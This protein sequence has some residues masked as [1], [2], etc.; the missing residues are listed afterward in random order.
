MRSEN[1]SVNILVFNCGSSS[2]KYKLIKMPQEQELAAGEAQRLGIK[3]Q[4]S[5]LIAHVA[6]STERSIAVHLPD[7]A[8]AFKKVIELLREDRRH[9]KSIF[10]DV[11]AHRYVHPEIFSRGR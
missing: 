2:L 1:S 3:T 9:D 7:H 4:D 6:R 11:F 5:S 10:F 8:A